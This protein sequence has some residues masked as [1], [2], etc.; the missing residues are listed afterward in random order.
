[1]ASFGALLL[2]YSYGSVEDLS[3]FDG[4]LWAFQFADFAARAG[5]LVYFDYNLIILFVES[6]LLLEIGYVFDFISVFV[7][8][9]D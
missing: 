6:F 1:M 7:N 3:D 5:F 8:N 4:A 9:L 2:I